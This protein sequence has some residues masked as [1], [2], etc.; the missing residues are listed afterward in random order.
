MSNTRAKAVDVSESL[1]TGVCSECKGIGKDC[2]KCD[3]DAYC[4]KCAVD[5]KRVPGTAIKYIIQSKSFVKA[6]DIDEPELSNWEIV[7][8]EGGIVTKNCTTTQADNRRFAMNRS[9][10]IKITAIQQGR[11]LEDYYTFSRGN[12]I[13]KGSYGTVSKVRCIFS[14]QIRALKTVQKKK[15]ENITRLKREIL[16]MKRLD[17][18]GIIR[19]HEVFEDES[20]IY[21]VMELCTGGELFERVIKA[22]RFSEQYAAR[23]MKQIFSVLAYI[24]DN[25]I[26]H[27]DLKPENLLYIDATPASK[28]KVID[29]GF[30][31]K[32][33]RN[34]KLT[35]VVGTPYYVAPE[36]LH[37]NYGE[38]CDLWSTGVIFYI[39]LCGYPP[40]YGADNKEILKKVKS[41]SYSFDPKHWSHRSKNCK[42]L[43]QQLLCFNVKG[44][45]TAR[46]ALRH[47]WIRFFDRVRPE[48]GN[49]CIHDDRLSP[50]LAVEIL[51]RFRIF[52]QMNP[53]KRLAV[54]ATAYM[55]SGRDL[56][57]STYIFNSLDKNSDGVLTRNEITDT[58]NSLG[59]DT[60]ELDNTLTLMDTDGNGTI[61]YTEFL[62][63]TIDP[64]LYSSE[65]LA[66]VAF[67]VFDINCEGV[68]T[69]DSVM[70]VLRCNNRLQEFTYDRVLQMMSGLSSQPGVMNFEDFHNLL[71]REEKIT[72]VG[73]PAAREGGGSTSRR[74]SSHREAPSKTQSRNSSRVV[75]RSKAPT[76]SHTKI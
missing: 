67:R 18:P 49:S 8:K 35:S 44:R 9:S 42:G 74:K 6:S 16:I 72:M 33:N 1:P 4:T 29:W 36:V 57:Q 41:G 27:R 69:V 20:N 25:D 60:S 3:N 39:S 66:R 55:I 14:E 47:D 2:L 38:E 30:A 56:G 5:P 34:H 43:L 37:G 68:V 73:L 58:F 54:T 28:L 63:S 65:K 19:L 53:I 15:I 62:A 7:G 24:H 59:F 13:G 10:M 31:L 23:L 52:A 11:Q 12:N 26:I 75:R 40:F 45:I 61:D 17:H 22:N 46:Q 70:R 21:F 50:R 71:K 51:N 64:A 48:E 32:C 76:P